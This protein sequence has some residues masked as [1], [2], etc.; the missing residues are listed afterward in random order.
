MTSYFVPFRSYLSLLFKFWTH[1]F[2][3]H[4][5]GGLGTTYDV[6]LGLIGKRVIDLLLVLIE[7]FARCYGWIATSEK[8]SKIGD[9][10]LTGPVWSKISG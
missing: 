4:P 3:S 8:M 5:F 1:A 9:F 10:A 7:L 6:N 2:L